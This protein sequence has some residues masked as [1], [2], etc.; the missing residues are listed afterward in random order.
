MIIFGFGSIRFFRTKTGSN[1][2]DSV[3]PVWLGLAQFSRFWLSFG[4]VFSGFS[5]LAR[6]FPVFFFRF[7]FGSVQFFG[8]R[9]IKSKPNRT[10][11]SKF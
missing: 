3:F 7:G 10:V 5:G 9:L 1:W 6:F 2:F 11:F 4:S 8:F